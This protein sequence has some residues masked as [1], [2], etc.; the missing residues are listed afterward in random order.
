MVRNS[1]KILEASLPTTKVCIL[2]NYGLFKSFAIK[3][4]II[5]DCCSCGFSRSWSCC[6]CICIICSSFSFCSCFLLSNSFRLNS[7][8]SAFNFTSISVFSFKKPMASE[9]LALFFFR[10]VV[11][12]SPLSFLFCVSLKVSKPSCAFLQPC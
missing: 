5:A 7:I 10:G 2:L 11:C 9:P 3:A 4:I 1:F 12:S 6:C 8:S